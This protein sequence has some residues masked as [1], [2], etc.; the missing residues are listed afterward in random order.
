MC[1]AWKWDALMKVNMGA[2]QQSMCEESEEQNG[3]IKGV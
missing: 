3:K 1:E 2:H